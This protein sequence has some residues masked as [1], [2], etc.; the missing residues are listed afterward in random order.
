MGFFSSAFSAISSCLSGVASMGLSLT[1]ILTVVQAVLAICKALG[2]FEDKS[3]EELGDRAIQAE[4]EGI[5]PDKFETFDEYV[6]AI[7]AFELDPE[8]SKEISAEEKNLKGAEVLLLLAAEKFPGVPIATFAELAPI[9]G[10][11]PE[12]FNDKALKVLGDLVKSDPTSVGEI[13][14]FLTGREKDPDAIS[15]TEARLIDIDRAGHDGAT[16][17]ESL[18]RIE[19]MKENA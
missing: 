19:A 4:R 10:K 14:S 6:K 11:N 18:R 5:T 9:I 8:R 13:A 12:T 15:R 16:R 2:L 7:K 1:G 3:P 17:A